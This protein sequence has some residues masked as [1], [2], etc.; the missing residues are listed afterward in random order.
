MAQ[1]IRPLD[2]APRLYATP[3]RRPLSRRWL[4]ASRVP[5]F[6]TSFLLESGGRRRLAPL[7]RRR[8]G[9]A[10]PP[11]AHG[12]AHLPSTGTFVLAANH[13][14]G[15][16]ALDTIA[17]ILAAANEARPDLADRYLLI[18]GQRVRPASRGT[19]L[20]AR[21][22][23]MLVGLAF[24][25]WARH[26]LRLP[27]GNTQRH[28]SGRSSASIA[29]LREWRRRAALQPSLVFPEGRARLAFEALRPGAGRWLATLGVPVLPVGVWW[30]DGVPH[31]RLGAPMRWSHRAE[32]RDAQLGLAIA[33]LLPSELV[34]AWAPA[35][36]RWR[37]AHGDQ[38][39]R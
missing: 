18:T 27:L 13:Y 4:A 34:P 12:L 1:H 38:G 3:A 11:Q 8:L 35:M 28:P 21:L 22:S 23:R 16:R 39:S 30:A 10:W 14:G 5:L 31:V 32:L 26:T 24:R 19:P 9:T 6:W 29:V 37:A 17:A 2:H 25:R 20:L 15:R 36:A 33:A 7:V